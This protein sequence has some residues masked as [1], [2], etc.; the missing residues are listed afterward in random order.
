MLETILKPITMDLEKANDLL[1]KEFAYMLKRTGNITGLEHFL[2][3]VS[4][5]PALV[6]VSSRIFGGNA[7]KTTIL[8]AV[9]QFVYF[10]SKVIDAISYDEPVP[11][12]KGIGPLSGDR[13]KVL[14]GDYFHSRAAVILQES[15]IKGMIRP[16][17]DIICRM[18][19]ARIQKKMMPDGATDIQTYRN[20]IQKESAE[21]IAGCCML[22]ARLAGASTEEQ[23][24]M[25]SYGCNLGMAIY[26]SERD[27]SPD[28][29]AHYL[30]KAREALLLIPDQPEKVILA[31]L[32][33][34]VT[35][36]GIK[37]QR[38]VG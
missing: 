16:L 36:S 33:E 18:Q 7:E 19:E 3:S 17:A 6:I 26:F 29:V 8:A 22:G 20:I 11:G 24:T 5:R 21:L 35:D 31:Q 12:I 28:L 38:L 13:F 34:K 14:L 10:A 37:T 30:D 15:G 25:A 9:M 23:E 32:I 27:G 1:K 2:V 4:L